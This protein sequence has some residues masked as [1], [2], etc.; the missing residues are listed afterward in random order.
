M[1]P[2]RPTWAG[3]GGA[4]SLAAA[5]VA[6]GWYTSARNGIG[7]N[8]S[9]HLVPAHASPFD[10]FLIVM[11]CLVLIG[12]YITIAGLT[13]SWWLPGVSK[14]EA[15]RREAPLVIDFDENDPLCVQD[16]RTGHLQPDLQLRLRVSNVGP[17]GVKGVRLKLISREPG[18]GF[19]H[20]LAIMHDNSSAH[21]WSAVIGARCP[22]G[23]GRFVYFDLAFRSLTDPDH[24]VFS[25]ADLHLMAEQS[26]NPSP[27]RP[28]ILTVETDGYWEDDDTSVPLTQ[29]KFYIQYLDKGGM[30]LFSGPRSGTS[31][32]HPTQAHRVL[33]NPRFS[34]QRS[35][36]SE[37]LSKV[38]PC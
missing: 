1:D 18:P 7:V 31:D 4:I 29:R 27:I 16:R 6:A 23:P 38:W 34:G 36:L 11:Y 5:A 17:V 28:Y 9:G 37:I 3:F 32:A 25:Y 24:A 26:I 15:R 8:S 12:L 13:G 21:S 20:Y 30:R 2:R 33:S 35:A 10:P 14:S 22:P 19:A